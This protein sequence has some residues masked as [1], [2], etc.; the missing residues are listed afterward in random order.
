VQV[1]VLT[2]SEK[3][4]DYASRVASLLQQAG[5]RVESKLSDETIKPKSATRAWRKPYMLIVGE[6]EQSENKVAV[7][8]R[9]RRQRRN[10]VD[11]FWRS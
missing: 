6:K 1:A 9:T 8:H 4:N 7:R 3:F 11:Q 5:L 2:I 10:P